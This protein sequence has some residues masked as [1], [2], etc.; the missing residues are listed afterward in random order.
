MDETE[1]KRWAIEQ[2]SKLPQ[3]SANGLIY[4]AERIMEF[5]KHRSPTIDELM[6]RL[7]PAG[8]GQ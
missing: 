1:L 8:D 4:D 7:N 3:H 5:V 2:A 6:E